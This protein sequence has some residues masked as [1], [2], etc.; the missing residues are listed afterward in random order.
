MVYIYDI[1]LNFNNDFY[2]FYEWE[3]NDPILHIKRMPIF[4]VETEFIEDLL[5]KKVEIDDSLVMSIF[6]KTEVF[7]NKK[8]RTLK[9]ACLFTD[10]Y[11]VVGVLLGDNYIVS[12]LS[13]LLLDEA[14]DA[15]DISR[16]CTLVNP[17]YNIV[18]NRKDYS[19]LTRSEIKVKKYLLSELKNAYK[20]Q[21][22]EK[23]EYLYFEYFGKIETDS[24]KIIEE[25]KETLKTEVNERH[26]M[27]FELLKLA[28]TK[29]VDSKI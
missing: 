7:D 28:N 8:L 11:R 5:T 15:I 26:L 9:Y 17:A 6:N 23:L 16:R 24:E 10:T 29:K 18:G 3:K 25:F 1:L 13:D 20:E 19:F 22:Q 2:E 14:V 21:A 12:K 27:L 4:K